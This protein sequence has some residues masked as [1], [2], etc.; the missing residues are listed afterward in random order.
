MAL[1]SGSLCLIQSERWAYCYKSSSETNGKISRAVPAC[2]RKAGRNWT[3]YYLWLV[4]LQSFN[5]RELNLL[6]AWLLLLRPAGCT[7]PPPTRRGHQNCSPCSGKCPSS[8]RAASLLPTPLL[9]SPCPSPAC[10]LL[11]IR[12]WSRTYIS[13][14]PLLARA[15]RPWSFSVLQQQVLPKAQRVFEGAWGYKS[16][17]KANSIVVHIFWK[18]EVLRL[19]KCCGCWQRSIGFG[20]G[21]LKASDTK[22]REISASSSR[23]WPCHVPIWLLHSNNAFSLNYTP[24]LQP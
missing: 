9:P 5:H 17:S 4:L 8:W 10:S 11:K 1:S 15:N 13:S 18:P 16:P 2:F 22:L 3:Y 7:S 14:S 23:K 24:G 19:I 20:F 6:T 21:G 12:K